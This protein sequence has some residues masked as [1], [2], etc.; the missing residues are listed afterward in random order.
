MV[1]QYF[2]IV[3]F[4]T[5]FGCKNNENHMYLN[6]EY[7][8]TSGERS[9]V[10]YKIEKKVK[11]QK[12]WSSDE[13]NCRCEFRTDGDY[14]GAVFSCWPPSGNEFQSYGY[15]F[16]SKMNCKNHKSKKETHYF[17]V[18]QNFYAWCSKN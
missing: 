4:F 13:E 17:F 18:C 5:L 1:F 2:I 12:F 7:G 15:K 9:E 14:F 8:P 11:D 10:K 16:Q 3:I 6:I